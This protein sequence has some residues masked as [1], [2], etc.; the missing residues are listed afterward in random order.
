MTKE[1]EKDNVLNAFFSSVFISKTGFQALEI[2][3]KV[4]SKEDLHSVEEFADDTNWEK[5]LMHQMIA[6]RVLSP[7]LGIFKSHLGRALG[8]LLSV[9]LL[10]QG[11]WTR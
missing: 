9:T 4:W 8:N 10:E 7:S 1:M 5:R 11:G 6:Q 2:R 3:G